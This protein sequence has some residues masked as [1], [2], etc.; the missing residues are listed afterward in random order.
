MDKSPVY[1][2]DASKILELCPGLQLLQDP[3]SHHHFGLCP[4]KNMA[5]DVFE[6]HLTNIAKLFTSV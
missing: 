4:I 5:I 2:A 1:E 6:A 3:T